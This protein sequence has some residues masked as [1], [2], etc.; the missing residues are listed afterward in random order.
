MWRRWSRWIEMRVSTT[1]PA[2]AAPRSKVAHVRAFRR[3][4]GGLPARLCLFV[5]VFVHVCSC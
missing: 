5:C 2:P 1:S 3:A 4:R